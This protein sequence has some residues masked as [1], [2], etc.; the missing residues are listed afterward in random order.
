MTAPAL[1]VSGLTVRFGGVIALADVDLQLEDGELLGLIGPNGA[2]KTT[3]IDA[4][5]GF[6]P[7]DGT[8]VA[9]GQRLDGL[10]PDRRARRG[11]GRTFQTLELFDD[12]SVV[13]NVS[14]SP[15]ASEPAVADALELTGLTSVADRSPRDLGP[16]PRRL[17]ALARALAAQPRVLLLDELAA[18]LDGRERA[19]LATHLRRIVET[20][21]S[22]LLVDHDLGLVMD[23]SDR[24]IV[25]DRGRKIADGAPGDVHRDQTVRDA[26]LGPPL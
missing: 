8:V 6:A 13:E 2:G 14:V 20:G 12:L 26:Y 15:L 4:I 22:V 1:F 19:E 10:R 24:V 7:Y 3:L 5:T 18:G 16:G 23:A 17:V 25:L 11:L 21:C 9:R